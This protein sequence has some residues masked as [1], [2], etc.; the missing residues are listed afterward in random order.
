MFTAAAV[1]PPSNRVWVAL[2]PSDHSRLGAE[3]SLL[4]P[5]LSSPYRPFRV[6]LG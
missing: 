4:R 3:N 1:R 6:R 5:L 2:R